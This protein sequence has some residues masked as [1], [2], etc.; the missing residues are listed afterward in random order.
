[1]STFSSYVIDVEKHSDGV[2]CLIV[3]SYLDQVHFEDFKRKL[4]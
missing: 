4:I 2:I 3:I 1:M